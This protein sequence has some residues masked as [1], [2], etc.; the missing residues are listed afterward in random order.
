MMAACDICGPLSEDQIDLFASPQVL[1]A[2]V[3]VLLHY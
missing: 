3:D 2:M 1:I